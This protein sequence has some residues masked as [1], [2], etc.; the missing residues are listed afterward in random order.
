M[1]NSVNNASFISCSLAQA[2][3]NSSFNNLIYIHFSFCNNMP[4]ISMCEILCTHVNHFLAYVYMAL[5]E[6]RILGKRKKSQISRTF[7]ALESL[8]SKLS[9]TD[10]P[11]AYVVDL[12]SKPNLNRASF[13]SVQPHNG[14]NSISKVEVHLF[15]G[16][17]VRCSADCTGPVWGSFPLRPNRSSVGSSWFEYEEE[18]PN[19]AWASASASVAGAVSAVAVDTAAE[20]IRREWGCSLA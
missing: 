17:T 19:R 8:T 15:T 13:L 20:D 7:T 11:K 10:G 6:K 4:S 1:W 18:G 16:F 14:N 5:R 2:L 9:T 12:T 3:C